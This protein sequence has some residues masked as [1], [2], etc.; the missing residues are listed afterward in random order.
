MG[1]F[2]YS[3]CK[4]TSLGLIEVHIFLQEGLVKVLN[5]CSHRM[6]HKNIPL[7]VYVNLIGRRSVLGRY[8]MAFVGASF[9]STVTV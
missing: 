5:F 1:Q 7:D 6:D 3:K 4:V 2:T 8:N 9:P